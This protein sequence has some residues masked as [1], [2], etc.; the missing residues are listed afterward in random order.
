MASLA[1][2]VRPLFAESGDLPAL[3]GFVTGGAGHLFHILVL[4]VREG[5]ISVFGRQDDDGV[6]RGSGEAGTE[7]GQGHGCDNPCHAR[8]SF[9]WVMLCSSDDDTRF[10]RYCKLMGGEFGC[11]ALKSKKAPIYFSNFHSYPLSP[12]ANCRKFAMSRNG[13][14]PNNELFIN[15]IAN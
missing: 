14:D 4:F 10:C 8:I 7:N 13:G 15:C 3:I 2:L 6:I 9:C 11:K 1:G 5:Y 12:A